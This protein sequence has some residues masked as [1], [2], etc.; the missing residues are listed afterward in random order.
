[1]DSP[2]SILN[3]LD[4]SSATEHGGGSGLELEAVGSEQGFPQ[5]SKQLREVM[6]QPLAPPEP[7]GDEEGRRAAEQCCIEEIMRFTW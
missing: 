2:S 4:A 7:R 1:M 3:A 5:L 6:A